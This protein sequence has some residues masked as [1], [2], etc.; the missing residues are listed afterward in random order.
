METSL[1]SPEFS[2]LDVD[3]GLPLHSLPERYLLF[4]PRNLH[5]QAHFRGIEGIRTVGLNVERNKLGSLKC[6]SL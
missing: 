5:R 2:S 6:S 3:F 4:L 1:V